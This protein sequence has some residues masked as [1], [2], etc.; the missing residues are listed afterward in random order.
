MPQ[1]PIAPQPAAPPAYWQAWPSIGLTGLVLAI[2]G[3]SAAATS[4][5]FYI[6]G[7]GSK[8]SL[9]LLWQWQADGPLSQAQ[10]IFVYWVSAASGFGMVFY[11]IGRNGGPSAIDYL[12]LHPVLPK[13]ILTW[14]A[15][16]LV[17]YSL[18]VMIPTIVATQ[19]GFA[20]P[21]Q[22]PE[23]LYF[24][25]IVMIA[26][27]L[28]EVI[29]RGF[30]FIGLLHSRASI[31]MVILLPT[32]IWTVAHLRLQVDWISDL[33]ALGIIFCF[34]IILSAARIRSNSLL[35]PIVLHSSW[36]ALVIMVD[37]LI[38]AFLPT[39]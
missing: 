36:N 3:L 26:P 37:A 8:I 15:G 27:V 34:G 25:T 32:I 22:R 7:D 19:K 14:L 10:Q 18:F 31:T 28:E 13:R 35:L 24:I 17:F 2:M 30:L 5:L 11:L 38:I 6:L 23:F 20:S 39:H 33:H 4:S 9:W 1:P 21:I 29:F 16:L 12:A